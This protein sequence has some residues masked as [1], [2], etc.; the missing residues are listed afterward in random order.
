M[1]AQRFWISAI[2]VAAVATP[3][4]LNA[5]EPVGTAFSYQ[6]QLNKAGEPVS[7]YADFQFTLWNAEFGGEPVGQMWE[8]SWAIVTDGLF[9]LLVDF[10][11]EPFA[12]DE[13][14]WL[15]IAVRSPAGFGD[16]TTL[17][18]R[19]RLTPTPFSLATRGVNVD[20]SGNVG[21][22][23]PSPAD[24]LDVAGAVQ[25]TGFKMPTDASSNRVL[26]SDVLGEGTW[27]QVA[28][29]M[30]T[31][32]AVTSTKI[33]DAT[34][35]FVDIGQ[36]KA[37]EGQVMKW[38]STARGSGSWVPGDDS[39]TTYNAG[40]GLSLDGS[41]FS[42]SG[43]TGDMITDGTIGGVDL[44]DLAVTG[45]KLAVNAVSTDKIVKSAVTRDKLNDAAVNTAKLNDAAV[46]STKI[47]DETIDFVDIA[48]NKATDG[49]VMKWS[50]VARGDGG[51]V[52]SDDSDTTYDAGA[53]LSLDGN[54]FSVSGVTGAMIT[55]GTIGG[56]DLDDL[57]VTGAKLAVNAV[58][59]DKIVKS[60]V[61]RDKLNDAAVD[62][63]KLNDA[64]VTSTKIE[65]ATISFADIG[66]NKADTGQVMKWNGSV[67]VAAND[68]TGGGGAG[69][70]VDDGAVVRLETA[71]DSVGIGTPTPA[72]KL[73]VDGNIRASGRAAF[74]P[75]HVCTGIHTFVAGSTNS[76][77]GDYS[78]IAGGANNRAEGQYSVVGGGGGP[79]ATDW[80][81]AEGDHCVVGGGRQNRAGTSGPPPEGECAT[82]CGGQMNDAEAT[83]S[84]IAGGERN[85]AH[86][87]GCAIGGGTENEAAG[88]W[89]TVAGGSANRAGG[90]SP[91][92]EGEF[93]TV[94]GGAANEASAVGAT[95]AG[96]R[97]NHACGE[98]SVVSG[99]D[100]NEARGSY[101]VVCG[102]GGLEP[103]QHNQ[104]L[105]DYCFIGGGRANLAG[106]PGMG[107]SRYATV[108]GGQGNAATGV[109]SVVGGGDH[110]DAVDGGCTVA[111][112]AQNRA[113]EPHATVGG[114]ESN[115]AFGQCSVV[116]GGCGNHVVGAYSTIPGGIENHTAGEYCLAAGSYAHADYKGSVVIAAHLAPPTNPATS[117]GNAQMVFHADGGL[118]ITNVQSPSEP[119]YDP[120]RLINTSTGA[121]LSDS[122][123]WMDASDRGLK[124]N[125]TPVD[126]RRLLDKIAALPITQWN[127]KGEQAKAR[128]MGPVAQDFH[129]VFGLGC[130]D[131]SIA[132]SD[133]GGVSLAAIQTLHEIVTEKDAQI[134]AL[135][136][137]NEKLEARLAALEAVVSGLARQ[138]NGDNR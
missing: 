25:M 106:D 2:I 56:V 18:P 67:W 94:G 52:P 26:A 45:A 89:C 70:W 86:G 31:D 109:A 74:G 123:L 115:E 27:R 92:P 75:D 16:F 14:R 19:Q 23:T 80:N 43:V 81:H 54:T 42:V 90:S 85:Q 107:E 44:D 24:K 77:T 3:A 4:V 133:L 136:K 59:T 41:T 124:E 9:T 114:G 100:A 22:G 13:A 82:V 118:Y 69:G 20:P 79:E 98:C 5:Q 125:F 37:T 129:A 117:G 93:A 103:D 97:N 119:P 78:T 21:I 62:T 12:A 32:D 113:E 91:P 29:D 64:A 122:G 65:D 83:N 120:S 46:T 15:E 95:V 10:D 135:Q 58:S 127:F 137:Q 57:A 116:G 72:E 60:A 33:Q 7:D 35:D 61:T 11:V 8:V 76:A 108:A 111:G 17:S 48:Q 101:S 36:N 132:A 55:D 104:A 51:W 96:G 105:N 112:G 88:P 30:L 50:A 63:A 134:T 130:D 6:G 49:Q 47:E 1:K 110:N 121:Y 66:R 34:I 131:K 126:G 71:S 40:A 73:D 138:Q 128:H 38:S 99:G 84:T 68:E 53:G 102:G 39:D 28:E 87:E